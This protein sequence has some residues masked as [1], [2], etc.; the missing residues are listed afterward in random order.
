VSAEATISEVEAV[1]RERAA[2]VAGIENVARTYV[3]WGSLD[4][5][6][7]LRICG[8]RPDEL[9]AQRYPMPTVT[10]PRVVIDPEIGGEGSVE[11][12]AVDGIIEVRGGVRPWRSYPRH[13]TNESQDYRPTAKRCTLWADLLANP[14]E[15]VPAE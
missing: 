8:R 10:R 2:Y 11:W 12:R 13:G 9:A 15:Q 1:K 7:A 4:G 14:T 5:E 3:G 6:N